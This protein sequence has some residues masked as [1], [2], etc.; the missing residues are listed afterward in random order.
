[1]QMRPNLNFAGYASDVLAHY[2]AAF[3]SDLEIIRFA[4]S[5]AAEHVPAD[6]GER[7]LYQPREK[8]GA[9]FANCPFSTV[10]G[11]SADPSKPVAERFISKTP[12][13]SA[14]LRIMSR[15]SDCVS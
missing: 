6:W 11:R 15:P 1:M 4:G 10:F 9:W 7:I 14:S 2:H 13:G 3:G 5:P 8:I 12:L